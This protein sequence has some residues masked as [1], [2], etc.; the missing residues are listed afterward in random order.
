MSYR[1]RGKKVKV[2]FE[3]GEDSFLS[4][5]S[6]DEFLFFFQN[7]GDL[8]FG[9][10]SASGEDRALEATK[11]AIEVFNTQNNKAEKANAILADVIGSHQSISI[12]GKEPIYLKEADN[13]LVTIISNPVAQMPEIR[14]AMTEIIKHT[15]KDAHIYYNWTEDKQSCTNNEI[16]IN[17]IAADSKV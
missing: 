17:I 14:S 15:S 6:M 5:S 12:K 3:E 10:G 1:K 9:S 13:L 4:V 7:C 8:Y 2:I 11:A 16:K